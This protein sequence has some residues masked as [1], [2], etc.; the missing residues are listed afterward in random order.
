M[1]DF[2]W[3]L[4]LRA[5]FIWCGEKYSSN[6]KYLYEKIKSSRKEHVV[7]T[8]FTFW[9]MKII[10][11][12]LQANESLIMACLQIYRELLS[13]ATF[14]RVHSNS[15]EV[16]YISLQNRYLNL[17]STCHIKLKFFF[18][19]KL[20]QTLLL[21]KYL[22]SVAAILMEACALSNLWYH[23]TENDVA[24]SVRRRRYD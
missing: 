6:N 9:P 13:L 18:W 24:T 7:R 8:C 20:L 21:P 22:I 14:L 16:S 15:E 2:F 11:Q 23:Y 10:F 4:Y 5:K 3:S 19:T 17:K 1:I 12:K